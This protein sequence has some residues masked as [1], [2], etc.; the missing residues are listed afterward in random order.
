MRI[1]RLHT[2]LVTLLFLLTLAIAGHGVSA[3]PQPA[4]P[5]RQ[6]SQAFGLSI[7]R[8]PSAD[9]T[10][11]VVRSTGR[12]ELR[13]D[14]AGIAAW[15]DLR[16]D[17]QRQ[18]NLVAGRS[19]VLHGLE[20]R[21]AA[22]RV[23]RATPVFVQVVWEGTGWSRS[24]TIWAA[25]Q[26]FIR[27]TGEGHLAL[28]RREDAITGAALQLDSE[29]TGALYLDAWTGEDRGGAPV[30]TAALAEG[31]RLAD[32]ADGAVAVAASAGRASITL[33]ESMGLRSPRFVLTD[34]PGPALTIRRGDVTLVAGQDYLAHWEQTT[35]MLTAQIFAAMPPGGDAASRTYNFLAQTDPA[36]SLGVL[37][38]TLTPEGLLQVDGNMPDKLERNS[39]GDTF[40]I[41]YIQS[42]ATISVT[43]AYQGP[44]AGV[45]FVLAGASQK[46][47]GPPESLLV[48]EF[49]VPGY[50]EY[51]LDG[52]LIDAEGK[53]LSA[54]PADS[55]DPLGVGRIIITIGDSITAGVFGDRV[56]AGEPGYPVTVAERSPVVS[57]DGRNFF[58]YDNE[59]GDR[60][61]AY[62]RGYQTSLNDLLT[63]CSGA[64]IFI[65]NDGFS[66]LRLGWKRSASDFP[67]PNSAL[68]ESRV[69]AYRDHIEKLDARYLVIA[70]GTND[71]F[72]GQAVTN[73]R[74]DLSLLIDKLRGEGYG[75]TIWLSPVPYNEFPTVKPE[76]LEDRKKRVINYN[77][78]ILKIAQTKGSLFRPVL[79][80]PNF[81]SYFEN[82]L[83]QLA[84]GTHPTQEGYE[85]MAKLWAGQ[86]VGGVG[87]VPGLPCQLFANQGNAPQPP[88]ELSPRIWMPLIGPPSFQT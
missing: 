40:F 26:V 38:R 20:N 13:L 6:A 73:F 21:R 64:P 61:A 35:G 87:A 71:A 45:E 70:L 14:E 16:R 23:E 46:V 63:A 9:G 47:F 50:G 4:P 36:L 25:G 28:A 81:Y 53:R 68:Y 8:E 1:Y 37:G 17:P 42:S 54:T 7:A 34:W 2:L 11:L 65:L 76:Q 57:A 5:S 15:Y 77:K 85:A 67:T 18:Q 29:E 33:P 78:E 32:A 51:R 84:D 69:A 31:S 27:S 3:A 10:T 44:A 66:G 43:G 74:N 56:S 80:G 24:Y 30:S 83:A 39:T 41:P 60:Q 19:L 59:N 82:N 58:Q 48:A 75:L 22:W 86:V 88:I 12:F 62:Y 79:V 72:D 52:Y 55:I 49:T